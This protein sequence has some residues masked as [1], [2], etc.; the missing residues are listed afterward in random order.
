MSFSVTFHFRR[1][2]QAIARQLATGPISVCA[3]NYGG[4]IESSEQAERSVTRAVLA[5]TLDPRAASVDDQ[6]VQSKT[7][8]FCD[9]SHSTVE[10]L[11][12][13]VLQPFNKT[14]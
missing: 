12:R 4:G 1:P 2:L 14:G 5:V 8:D 7:R 3:R 9:L 11:V 13:R 6:L 10:F